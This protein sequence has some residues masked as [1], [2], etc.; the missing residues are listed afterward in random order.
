MSVDAVLTAVSSWFATAL[1]ASME[2]PDGWFGRPYDNMHRLT[3]AVQRDNK[4]F[5]EL[6]HQL[7]LVLSDAELGEVNGEDLELRCS[8]VVFDWREYGSGGLRHVTAYGDGGRVCFHAS[9][10]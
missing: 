1:T 10:T 6:D 7:H 3:W 4:L 9:G 5:L 2:L 8:Q